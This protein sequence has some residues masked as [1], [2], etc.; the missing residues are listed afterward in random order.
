MTSSLK[1]IFT[2]VP[3][4]SFSGDTTTQQIKDIKQW[5]HQAWLLLKHGGSDTPYEFH[6]GI[7]CVHWNQE[8]VSSN[9]SYKIDL[10]SQ[11]RR[12]FW[13]HKYDGSIPKLAS[14]VDL[15]KLLHQLD[16]LA[17]NGNL[18]LAE[19]SPVVRLS[20]VW[21]VQLMRDLTKEENAALLWE[22]GIMPIN[23]V[24]PSL[25]KNLYDGMEK[26]DVELSAAYLG[27]YSNGNKHTTYAQYFEHYVTPFINTKDGSLYIDL[28]P[29]HEFDYGYLTLDS[30]P[31][32]REALTNLKGGSL[33]WTTVK[34]ATIQ[35]VAFSATLGGSVPY[36]GA[37]KQPNPKPANLKYGLNPQIEKILEPIKDPESLLLAQQELTQKGFLS[38]KN[39]L[40]LY[41]PAAYGIWPP[42]DLS[43]KDLYYG[44]SLQNWLVPAFYKAVL[45]HEEAQPL[46]PVE[47]NSASFI[48]FPTLLK[49][50]SNRRRIVIFGRAKVGKDTL[51]QHIVNTYDARV[52]SFADHMKRF[53]AATF[54]FTK[55]QL[56]GPSEFRNQ[57]DVRFAKPTSEAWTLA[58]SGLQ[59]NGRAFCRQ[60][61]SHP[62]SSYN[63]HQEELYYCALLSWFRSLYAHTP[64]TPRHVL[65]TLGTEWGR[66]GVRSTLWSADVNRMV[67]QLYTGMMDYDQ[68]KGLFISKKR[69]QF[70]VTADGRFQDELT[71]EHFNVYVQR[72]LPEEDFQTHSSEQTKFDMNKFNLIIQNDGTPEEMFAKFDAAIKKRFS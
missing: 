24:Y 55:E 50:P 42:P 43:L 4:I 13:Y 34:A 17:F 60:L 27:C 56:W 36:P 31:A 3:R 47:E 8:L 72:T 51:A 38:A 54:G 63:E 37:K 52:I 35:D 44:Q 41:T 6:Q 19:Y 30:L 32:Y 22:M 58:F 21:G 62:G 12:I 28:F 65:Q 39:L 67:A 40:G 1:D 49:L 29:K 5:N 33:S 26:I 20:L 48:T 57:P 46:P 2:V 66:L 69:P 11:V 7:A 71:A 59:H 45:Q 61:M 23:M 68:T 9:N 14:V 18:D 64:L 25:A 53:C 15:H 16:T 70:I 10:V